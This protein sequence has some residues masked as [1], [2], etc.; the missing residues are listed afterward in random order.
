MG[1]CAPNI[2]WNVWESSFLVRVIRAW[3]WS[4]SFPLNYNP[5]LMWSGS[6]YH[7]IQWKMETYLSSIYH[8]TNLWHFYDAYFCSEIVIYITKTRF[9]V[10]ETS[11]NPPDEKIITRMYGGR[12]ITFSN[13]PTGERREHQR[14]HLSSFAE[15]SGNAN[16]L[17]PLNGFIR[18][19]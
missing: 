13:N 3:T 15:T 5:S 7:M 1:F 11:A 8:G 14:P 10:H 4:P 17:R 2:D 19:K 6:P 18:A 9:T 16:Q 12:N